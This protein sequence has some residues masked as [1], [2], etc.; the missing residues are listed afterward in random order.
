MHS[1]LAELLEDLKP[2]RLWMSRDGL[3]PCAN[4]D[5]GARSG[6]AEQRQIDTLQ[7]QHYAARLVQVTISQARAGR[8]IEP[9][10]PEASSA[11]A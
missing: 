4:G 1:T 5:A 3:E 10:S 6:L 11:A 8:C 2:V 9:A 7:A